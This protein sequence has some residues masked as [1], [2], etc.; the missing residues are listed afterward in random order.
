M[1]YTLIALIGLIALAVVV[2]TRYHS[3]TWSGYP[4]HQYQRVISVGFMGLSLTF[5]GAI[6]LDLRHVH[7]FFEGTKWADGPIWSQ[8]GVGITLLAVAAF[9]AWRMPPN[10]TRSPVTR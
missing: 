5:A 1:D 2:S 10:A 8:I 9:L 3:T 6:G 4:G 7:G